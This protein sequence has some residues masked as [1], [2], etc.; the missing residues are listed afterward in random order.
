MTT[1]SVKIKDFVPA[2]CQGYIILKTSKC[3]AAVKSMK[4]LE[5]CKVQFIIMPAKNLNTRFV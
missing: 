4:C 2:C 1:S 5:V 3:S